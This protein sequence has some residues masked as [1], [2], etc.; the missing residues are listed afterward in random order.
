M[1]SRAP[2][3]CSATSRS[4]RNWW[5]WRR[6]IMSPR[7]TE[8]EAKRSVEVWLTKTSNKESNDAVLE[9][10]ALAPARADRRGRVRLHDAHRDARSRRDDR[11]DGRRLDLHDARSVRRE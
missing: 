2:F 6:S 9:V 3:A 4:S 5:R 1:K 10:Q 11:R 8:I 7:L